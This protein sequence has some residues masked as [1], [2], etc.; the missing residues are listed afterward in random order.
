MSKILVL[1]D[2]RVYISS[3]AYIVRQ[4]TTHASDTHSTMLMNDQ[5]FQQGSSLR[6]GQM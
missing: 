2:E 4:G 3:I 5:S 6:I 1:Q